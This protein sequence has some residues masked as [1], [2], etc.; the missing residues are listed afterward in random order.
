M[1]RVNLQGDGVLNPSRVTYATLVV[2]SALVGILLAPTRSFAVSKP[3]TT[4]A[5]FVIVKDTPEQFLAKGTWSSVDRTDPPNGFSQPLPNYTIP[6]TLNWTFLLSKTITNW[7]IIPPT[8][9]HDNGGNNVLGYIEGFHNVGPHP[10]VDVDPNVL[11]RVSA[12][13]DPSIDIYFD[14]KKPT[15]LT[16]QNARLHPTTTS[17]KHWDHYGFKQEATA[18]EGKV[19]HGPHKVAG[20][21]VVSA[22]HTMSKTEAS[23]FGPTSGSSTG[24]GG[25]VGFNGATG[26]LTI[27]FG[28][29]NIF[30][31]AGSIAPGIAARYSG[32]PILNGTIPDVVL[33]Y[34]GPTGDGGYRF[35]S[36]VDSLSDPE[37]Q[38]KIVAGFSEYLIY[39]TSRTGLIDSYAIFDTMTTA[40]IGGTCASTFLSDFVSGNV[41]GEGLPEAVWLQLQGTCLTF[42]T[43]TNLATITA[44]FTTSASNIPATVVISGSYITTP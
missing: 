14:R 7:K 22:K 34:L 32:D 23:L 20:P 28:T 15:I 42:R 36:A 29:L 30:N 17:P 8:P 31:S 5:F 39:N 40:D 24:G 26:R 13:G 1:R 4:K 9:M 12:S 3:D 16:A 11:P 37:G 38:I 21:T 18:M 33:Q 41:T 10:S 19:D 44:G 2:L 35:G 6:G 27:H 25:R 43:A